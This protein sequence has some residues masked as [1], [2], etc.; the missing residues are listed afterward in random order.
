[1]ILAVTC[2]VRVSAQESTTG[3]IAGRVIDA[4]NLP[5][6]GAT[7]TI[8]SPQGD[9]TFIT[10]SA[11]RFFAPFLT[12]GQYEVKV[13]LSG[14]NSAD[15]PG[16]AVSVGQR[17]DLTLALQVQSVTESVQVKAETPLIDTTS[18]TTG[19]TLDSDLLSRVPV[20]RRF[21]DA[22][23]LAPGVSSRRT[24]LEPRTRRSPE[25][26]ASRTPTSS[27]AS[28]S[29]MAPTARSESYSIIFGSLGNGIPF[30]FIQQAQVKTGGY[31]AEF[32]QASGGVVNVIT[33]SG[34]NRFAGSVFAYYRPEGLESSYDQ[35]QTTNGTVNITGTRQD[36]FGG[37]FGGP[38][39][40]NKLFVFGA[41]DPEQSR[42]DYVA[43]NGFPL[44]SL[45]SVRRID[46]SRRTQRRRPGR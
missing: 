28:T 4:Q 37:V 29:P 39:V 44:Q 2:A 23:Y 12:P 3:S 6:P 8:I 25:A 19:A 26:A 20:G 34:T 10:D 31:Q 5:I 27:T 18:T 43:P 22:L 1:M 42:V 41:I 45:G 33:K 16:I 35:V 21:S 7:V 38:V 32:G 11:G 24:G 13:E 46:A 9:R 30:D 40:P 15:R 14:F 36:D 17:V